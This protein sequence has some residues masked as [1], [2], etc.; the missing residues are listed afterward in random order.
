MT[1]PAPPV[2]TAGT[3]ITAQA[4][5]FLLNPPL[6]LAIQS[7]TQSIANNSYTPFTLAT[8]TIDTYGGWDAGQPTRYTAQVAGYYTVCGVSAWAAAGSAGPR[9]TA[10]TKNGSTVPGAAST[11]ESAA[12]NGN[13]TA[14]PTIDIYLAAG[15]Y[16]QVR[17]LQI[18]GSSLNS[19]G[20]SL[21][22]RWSRA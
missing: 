13:Q 19:S 20:S 18:T 10:I 7:G 3:R 6:F 9:G 12:G 22:C 11:A 21:W 2:W 4:L 16:I 14:T 8:P 15:D 1:L 5:A 17:G